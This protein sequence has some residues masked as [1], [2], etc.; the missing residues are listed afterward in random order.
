MQKRKIILYF[1][2]GDN[3]QKMS[4][5]ELQQIKKSTLSIRE[6]RLKIEFLIIKKNLE[7]NT[8]SNMPD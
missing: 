8:K 2:R 3:S 5:L 4:K 6:Y 1:K 7:I